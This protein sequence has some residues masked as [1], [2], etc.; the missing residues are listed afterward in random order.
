METVLL[1]QATQPSPQAVYEWLKVAFVVLGA[2]LTLFHFF[3]R[4][5]KWTMSREEML[6]LLKTTNE[7]HSALKTAFDRFRQRVL[8]DNALR[9][10]EWERME[11]LI[12]AFE[13]ALNK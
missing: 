3:N 11:R 5:K 1:L 9:K 4:V 7:R 10:K 8:D 6:E 13:K 2:I 12:A